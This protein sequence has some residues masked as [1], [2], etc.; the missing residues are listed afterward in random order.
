MP[1]TKMFM[2]LNKVNVSDSATND[3]NYKSRQKYTL[4]L[5]WYYLH[6]NV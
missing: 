4:T 1:N 3:R 5:K 6:R 2:Q